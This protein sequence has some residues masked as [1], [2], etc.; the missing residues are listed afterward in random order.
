[1]KYWQSVGVGSKGGL[2]SNADFTRWQ[3]WLND[4]GSVKGSIDASKLWTNEYN[5]YATQGTS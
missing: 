5:P 3:G 2:L 4:T 1:L